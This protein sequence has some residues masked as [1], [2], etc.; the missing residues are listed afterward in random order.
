MKGGGKKEEKKR[1]KEK[2]KKR[3]HFHFRNRSVK[4][5]GASGKNAGRSRKIRRR[6]KKF[7][8]EKNCLFI[9]EKIGKIRSI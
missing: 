3:N 4:D 7:G 9:A 5:T 1:R 2:R 6:K 8:G